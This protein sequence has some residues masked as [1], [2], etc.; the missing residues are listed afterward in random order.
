MTMAALMESPTAKSQPRS[1]ERRIAHLEILQDL[2][3]AEPIW[4][5]LEVSQFSTPYQ[6]F[7]FLSAWQRHVGTDEQL[8]PSII[9]AFDAQ[10]Q[11]LLLLPLVLGMESGVRVARFMG[12][13]H[14]T[15]NMALW[16]QDFAASATRADLDALVRGIGELPIRIDVLAFTR[17]PRHWRDLQNPMALLPSQPFSQRLSV[18][19]IFAGSA[20]F[21]AH[22][23]LISTP[24]QRQG[25]QARN[26]ARLSLLH[27]VD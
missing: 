5:N 26:T 13:K 4:R 9:V 14:T 1:G 3:E 11:P 19:D 15:F 21:G 22:Q 17:Q 20:A 25:T 18:D 7:D 2:R 16:Q 23:Q 10:R 8:L 12:G 27:G 24:A 6:Q